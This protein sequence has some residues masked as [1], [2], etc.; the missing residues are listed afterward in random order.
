MIMENNN[1]AELRLEVDLHL[2]RI[3]SEF[4]KMFT[5]Q[6]QIPNIL[7]RADRVCYFRQWLV[8]LQDSGAVCWAW[9]AF[10]SSWS[11]SGDVSRTAKTKLPRMNSSEMFS[12]IC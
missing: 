12:I 11:S 10:T 3:C 8:E 1:V 2:K 9:E 5:L 6:I 7:I 4:L